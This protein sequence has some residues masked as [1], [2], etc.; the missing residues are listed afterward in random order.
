MKVIKFGGRYDYELKELSDYPPDMETYTRIR[1][2]KAPESVKGA[3]PGGITKAFRR[4]KGTVHA[5]FIFDSGDGRI[6][7][8]S[9]VG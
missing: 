2:S 1:P 6:W 5:D 3:V 7:S 8:F 4:P 9:Q